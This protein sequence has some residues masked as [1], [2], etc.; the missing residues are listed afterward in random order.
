MDVCRGLST[1][2]KLHCCPHSIPRHCTFSSTIYFADTFSSIIVQTY[3]KKKHF[4]VQTLAWL[5]LHFMDTF[6]WYISCQANLPLDQKDMDL[7]GRSTNTLSTRPTLQHFKIC[8]R[9]YC[10]KLTSEIPFGSWF[11]SNFVFVISRAS[12][13]LVM[14]LSEVSAQC[15]GISCLGPTHRRDLIENGWAEQENSVTGLCE[16]T[17]AM[18]PPL[19]EPGKSLSQSSQKALFIMHVLWHGLYLLSRPAESL[20]VETEPLVRLSFVS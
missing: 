12:S 9:C 4:Q 17:P 5:F 7:Y 18:Q 3:I 16:M 15:D 19:S 13:S 10:F 2:P 1:D 20:H 11:E 6:I 14:V 8:F